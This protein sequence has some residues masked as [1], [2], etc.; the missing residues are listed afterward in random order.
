MVAQLRIRCTSMWEPKYR[1]H[2][3]YSAILF[4]SG[5][6]SRRSIPPVALAGCST[7]IRQMQVVVCPHRPLLL[8]FRLIHLSTF[9]SHLTRSITAAKTLL[10]FVIRLLFVRQRLLSQ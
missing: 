5:L 8:I 6:S 10:H 2:S 7:T 4:A 3:T 9:G 1:L